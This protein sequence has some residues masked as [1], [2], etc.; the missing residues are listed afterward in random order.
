MMLFLLL[1]T[2]AIASMD[3]L[4]TEKEKL[5]FIE[6]NIVNIYRHTN[7]PEVFGANLNKMVRCGCTHSASNIVWGSAV[8]MT[9][10]LTERGYDEASCG[11]RCLSPRS[12][13]VLL[14]CPE[15]WEADCRDGCVPPM[16]D[17]VSKRAT[18]LEK[19]V[20]QIV[21]YGFDYLYIDQSYIDTCGCVDRLRHIRYGSQIGLDCIFNE[22]K[23]RRNG[24]DGGCAGYGACTNNDNEPVMLFC[25]AGHSPTCSGCEKNLKANADVDTRYDWMINLLTG[26][27][28]ESQP[29]LDILPTADKAQS[30]GCDSKMQ[31]VKYGN[32][33]GW[34][35]E[36]KNADKITED[37]GANVLCEDGS[38][39]LLLHLCPYGFVPNCRDGCGYAWTAHEDL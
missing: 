17:S 38:K 32:G 3:E 20:D 35:C 31:S 19:N 37:C 12:E 7:I 30:C 6:R 34:S 9:C 24:E 27:I 11:V 29:L 1:I 18:F 23:W 16:F 22:D 5:A 8:G 14:M 25:P 36:V 28:R 33:I 4:Q 2:A 15:N 39:K 10:K 13:N 26:W 21:R